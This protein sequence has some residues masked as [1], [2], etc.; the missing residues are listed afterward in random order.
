[1]FDR[2][3][4]ARH[5]PRCFALRIRRGRADHGRL[6]ATACGVIRTSPRSVG[7]GSSPRDELA[8][9]C[10]SPAVA[11]SVELC[12]SEQRA[13]RDVGRPGQRGRARG[14]GARRRTGDAV[15]PNEVKLAVT[16]TSAD[17]LAVQ[18]MVARLLSLRDIPN[19]RRRRCLASRAAITGACAC[20][21]GSP[22][23]SR[24]DRRCAAP[25]SSG[26]S[27]EVLVEVAG[28]GYRCGTDERVPMLEPGANTSSTRINTYVTTR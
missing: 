20:S 19:R 23:G 25:C 2:P 12:S 14:R 11:L 28:V 7:R 1:V 6:R 18:T 9:S 15:Q 5:R 27:R 22:I 21:I 4:R 17:K 8:G 16:A 3:A 13:H 10:R 24:R 26:V